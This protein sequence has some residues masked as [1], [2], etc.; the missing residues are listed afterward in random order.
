MKAY[1]STWTPEAMQ[2][3]PCSICGQP[4]TPRDQ[5]TTAAGDIVCL[6]CLTEAETGDDTETYPSDEGCTS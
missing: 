1:R 2:D 5:C 3:E 4:L 6:D